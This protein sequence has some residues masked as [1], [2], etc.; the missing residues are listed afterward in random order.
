MKKILIFVLIAFT[1]TA[2]FAQDSALVNKKGEAIL[3]V[4]GDIAIGIEATPVFQYFGNFLNNTANNAA[5]A[6]T[7]LDGTTIFGK[8]FLDDVTAVRARLEI[9]TYNV[10]DNRYVRDD[11][12]FYADPLSNNLVIDRQTLKGSTYVLGLEYEKR[13][14]KGRLQGFYGGGV[15]FGLGNSQESYQYGNAFSEVYPNP[16]DF[17]Y[18][19]N[20][21]ANGD[22]VL[23]VKD[24]RVFGAGL[25]GFIGVEYFI[26]P[27]ISLGGELGWRLLYNKSGQSKYTYE[28]WNGTAA[29]EKL[30]L[31]SPGDRAFNTFTSNPSA[32]IFI[33]FHF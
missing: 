28:T 27:N 7:F 22:R 33:M 12:A 10:T 23:D 32:G 11:A 31:T 6:L 24:G 8:Y 3:P 16:T 14:G 1:S 17:N 30:M 4:A 29:E 26:M 9:T 15:I 21:F 25:N 20:L 5:P 13:R 19:T 2:I 18:G